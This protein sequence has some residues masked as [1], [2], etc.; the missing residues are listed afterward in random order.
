MYS[1]LPGCLCFSPRDF[2][3]LFWS[4]CCLC[5]CVSFAV[6]ISFPWVCCFLGDFQVFFAV[7][8]SF[9]VK[10]CVTVV[11]FLVIVFRVQVLR[12][13]DGPVVLW[14]GT[15]PQTL[16]LKHFRAGF[17]HHFCFLFFPQ[18]LL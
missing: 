2:S 12:Y 15:S 1:F 3:G 8:P 9:I 17:S 4:L 6:G 18:F 14:H 5:V 11:H 10:S 13:R 16:F 7:F